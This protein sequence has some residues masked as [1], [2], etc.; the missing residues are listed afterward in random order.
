MTEEFLSQFS[1]TESPIGNWS[2]KFLRVHWGNQFANVFHPF[3]VQRY[4]TTP[5]PCQFK[6]SH[7]RPPKVNSL[8]QIHKNGGGRSAGEGLSLQEGLHL[9]NGRKRRNHTGSS[10]S[11]LQMHNPVTWQSL[12]RYISEYQ[13]SSERK[14][15]HTWTGKDWEAILVALCDPSYFQ[16]SGAAGL[17]VEWLRPHP[18]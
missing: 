12:D 6:Q 3:S 15:N 1:E 14:Q 9:S 11:L 16:E 5:C 4:R 13:A 18:P 7:L 17:G 8:V 2:Q 10:T